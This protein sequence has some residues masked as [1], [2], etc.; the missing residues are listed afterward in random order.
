MIFT[1]NGPE[2]GKNSHKVLLNFDLVLLILVK[3][4]KNSSQPTRKPF[5][6]TRPRNLLGRV[7]FKVFRGFIFKRMLSIQLIT[8]IFKSR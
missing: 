3:I 4:N 7:I 6:R 1:R 2:F 8:E 5:K